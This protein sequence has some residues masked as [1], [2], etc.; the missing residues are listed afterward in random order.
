[1]SYQY[2]DYG[3]QSSEDTHVTAL[4][5]GT[6]KSVLPAPRIGNRAT[7]VLDVGCGNGAIS[8]RLEASDYD[9]TGID[10]SEKGIDQARQAHPRSRFEVAAADDRLLNVLGV[11]PFD[12]IVSTEVIE[13]L[14]DPRSFAQGCL[15]ALNPGGLFVCSTPYHGYLKNLALSVANKWDFHANPLWDGGHIK[16]WSRKTLYALLAESGFTNP[17]FRGVGR[18]PLMWMSMVVSATKPMQR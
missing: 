8:G 7:R 12:V 17:Q 18:F 16:L 5:W 10:L 13:H 4:L 11:E 9:V 15:K 1:M 3:W 14:Y 6:L 2:K